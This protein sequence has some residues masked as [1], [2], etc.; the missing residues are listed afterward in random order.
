LY[1]SS[2]ADLAV[3]AY[4]AVIVNWQDKRELTKKQHAELNARVARDQPDEGSVYLEMNGKPCVNLLTVVG[5]ER[6]QAPFPVGVLTKVSNGEPLGLR[7]RSGGWSE[8]REPPD[9]VGISRLVGTD[10]QED[11]E[12]RDAVARALR[13]GARSRAQRL[14]KAARVP[15]AVVVMTRR[16]RRNPDVAAEV[17]Q[18]ADG[19]CEGCA[20]RAPFARASDG[21][22]YLEVHH[23]V[24]LANGGEDTVD[25]AIALCPNC[26]RHRHFG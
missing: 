23:R 26:H 25:N 10:V 24:T 2:T 7:T 20:A 6:L 9:W 5:M 19:T 16:F 17:L 8:V 21:S 4:R 13:D 15:E 11:A 12:Y 18:R 14:A 22:P 3:V 1:L